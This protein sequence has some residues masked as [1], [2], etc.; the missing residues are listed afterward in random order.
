MG[1]GDARSSASA[2]DLDVKAL[3]GQIREVLRKT[4]LYLSEITERFSTASFPAITRA[5]GDLHALGELWQDQV[6][7]HCLA[8]SPSAALPP[9]ASFPR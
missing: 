5:L 1:E 9:P 7:R 4:P 8:G 6:G 2:T 3:A